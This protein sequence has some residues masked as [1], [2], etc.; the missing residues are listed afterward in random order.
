MPRI[1]DRRVK[2]DLLRAAEGVFAERGLSGARIA[3]ITSR[4]GVSKGAF[5]LHFQS[6]DDC[7][8]QI[9]ESF[10]ARLASCVERPA[11]LLD[12]G[13]AAAGDLLERIHAQ[14]V[15]VIEFCWQN[16]GLLRMMLL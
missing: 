14:D 3:D 4:A 5:Y 8:Q 13:A 15:A 12:G 16:R 2:I 1:A 11:D 7:F 6:K 9:V 10:I